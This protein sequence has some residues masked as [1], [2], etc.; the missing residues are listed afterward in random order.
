MPPTPSPRPSADPPVWLYLPYVDE[1]ATGT[2]RF[3]SQ[4][5][6]ALRRSG[7]PF[8]LLL[9][10]V[11]GSPQWLGGIPYR[12][13]F[14][15]AIARTLPRFAVALARVLWLQTIF[16]RTI[17]RARGTVLLGLAAEVAPFPRF[18]QFGVAHD[19]T[20]F[21]DFSE[22][23]GFGAWVKNGLWKAGLRRSQ[24]TI[25]I[26]QATR[27]DVVAIFGL[28]PERVHVVYEGFDPAVFRPAAAMAST[29]EPPYLFYAGT[30]DPHKNMPFAFE[31]YARLRARGHRVGFK[32]A[33]SQPP[34]RAEALRAALPEAIRDDV[35]FLG[36]VTDNELA[37][38]MQGCAAFVF[39]SRNE[40]FGLAPVEAMACGAPVIAA[41]AG[42]LPEVIAEGGVLLDPDDHDAWTD[43][44]ERLLVDEGH[45]GHLSERA[46]AR[47]Q[48][49]SWDKAAADFR[50]I[51]ESTA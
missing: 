17:G 47:A 24:G 33:G 38:L 2:Q 5:I 12:L 50:A 29:G 20:D 42:S 9:G 21:R 51:L 49:F 32:L 15:P 41:A 31:V 34:R 4:M 45:C 35:R 7:L 27:N 8:R 16:P 11:H 18:R 30:L 40:G 46:L 3:A 19:L 43:E 26:S 6:L 10:E 39:P 28:S 23:M 36:Y 1:R 13:M 22:R 44:V 25:A 14:G 37:K 48:S